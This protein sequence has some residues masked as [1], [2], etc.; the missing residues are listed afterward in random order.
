M[1]NGCSTLPGGYSW[2]IELSISSFNVWLY[3]DL[4]SPQVVLMLAFQVR[5]MVQLE[6][7]ERDMLKVR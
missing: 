1:I 2:E 6:N 5:P 7:P 3:V 4:V